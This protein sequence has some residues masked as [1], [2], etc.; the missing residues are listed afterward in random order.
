VAQALEKMGSLRRLVMTNYTWLPQVPPWTGLLANHA[1]QDEVFYRASFEQLTSLVLKNPKMS[2]INMEF[3]KKIG[4]WCVNL[5][6]F[7]LTLYYR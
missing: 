3:L 6:T 4:L 1:P 5:T 7:T 2:G